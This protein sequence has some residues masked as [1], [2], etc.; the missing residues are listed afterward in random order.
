MSIDIA[1]TRRAFDVARWAGRRSPVHV[2]QSGSPLAELSVILRRRGTMTE[3]TSGGWV[4]TGP[5]DRASTFPRTSSRRALGVQPG[6]PGPEPGLLGDVVRAA[7]RAE[8]RRK[9]GT[10]PGRAEML[11]GARHLAP[12]RLDHAEPRSTPFHVGTRISCSGCKGRSRIRRA[13][14]LM[15]ATA[16]LLV[17]R[18]LLRPLVA[19]W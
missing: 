15:T 1:I 12:A 3:C 19:G 8:Q 18:G 17:S 7:G 13:T 11:C 9:A 5:T 4:L 6:R 2:E 16:W 10:H 14:R